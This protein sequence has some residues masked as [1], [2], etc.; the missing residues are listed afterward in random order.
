MKLLELESL[1][2]SIISEEINNQQLMSTAQAMGID[3]ESLRAWLNDADPTPRK[4][5]AF[6]LLCS[7]KKGEIQPEDDDRIRAM[8]NR[9]IQLRNARQIEDIMQF[10]DPHSLETRIEQLA[11]V[12]AKRQGFSGF[13]PA[14]LPGV[15]VVEKRPDITFYKVSNPDSL[16]KIGEGTK[17][18]TR[19]SY[20]N[21]TFIA[22]RY[23]KQY[24]YLLVG[25]KNN[26]PYVQFNPDYS[27]VMDVDDREFHYSRPGEA[28]LLNLPSPKFLQSLPDNKFKNEKPPFRTVKDRDGAWLSPNQQ[29]LK[30]W[31]NYTPQTNPEWNDYIEYQPGHR[32]NTRGKDQDYEN[33]VARSILRTD[34]YSHLE[35]VMS[36]WRSYCQ[37]EIP[38]Q[39]SPVVEKAIV[40][41]DY[42]ESKRAGQGSGAG[43]R[44]KIAGLES[45]IE[46]V[47]NNVRG[48][49]P[50]FEKK[51]ENDASNSIRY[52]L[53]TGLNPDNI[54]SGIV[55]DLVLFS[56][57]IKNR[58]PSVSGQ[59]FENSIRDFVTR[60]RT[61]LKHGQFSPVLNK[62]IIPYMK[63]TKKTLDKIVTPEM[64]RLL[65]RNRAFKED[66]EVLY[67]EWHI[68][69]ILQVQGRGNQYVE[70][71]PGD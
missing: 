18:C 69:D 29:T 40:D 65:L 47:K 31:L 49:W 34:R 4:S 5:F 50:E 71:E 56:K 10:P 62:V 39:R 6:W 32:K 28:K 54:S 14:S 21:N 15:E 67:K 55:K 68:F 2:E 58:E 45:I 64:K 66:V 7:L 57:F 25:Y 59:E 52:Y 42:T 33:R 27:Q 24:G 41:K 60:A 43:K 8:L 51:I 44:I 3:P 9:F 30:N 19:F 17:W 20:Q 23:I 11:G 22:Q 48:N 16:A 53:G 70:P 26:K 38:G 12:G 1:L 13:D 63:L 46:Y 35:R 36:N 37:N 61:Q